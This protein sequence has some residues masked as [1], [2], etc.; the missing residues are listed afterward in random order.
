MRETLERLETRECVVI[1]NEGQRIFGVLHRPTHCE[2]PPIVVLMHG[3]A[4]SKHGSNR[5]YVTLAEAFA[6]EGIAALRFDFR[7]SGDSEGTLSDITFDDLVSDAL[8]VLNH[9]ESIEGIDTTR[10]GL[11]G[12]SLGGAISVLS[13]ARIQ[14]IQAL[15]L[16][17]PVA[18]GEL[19]YRDFL[20]NHPEHIT[21]DPSKVLSSYKGVKLHPQFREQFGRMSACKALREIPHIPVLLM[22]GE[23]DEAVSIAHQ[24]AFRQACPPHQDNLRLVSYPDGEHSLGFSSRFPEV[25]NESVRWFQHYL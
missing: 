17:A 25:I 1:E 22:H 12:A 8:A 13:A 11:F 6:K 20:K 5:C 3:F 9:L 18:S 4:S 19:W 2:N 7:G 23:K 21:S 16:W 24:E 15:A 14:K 10:I